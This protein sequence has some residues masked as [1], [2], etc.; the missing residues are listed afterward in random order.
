ML[1]ALDAVSPIAD[2]GAIGACAASTVIDDIDDIDGIDV[3]VDIGD[4]AGIDAS[5]A[6]AKEGQPASSIR[7]RTVL[8]CRLRRAWSSIRALSVSIRAKVSGAKRKMLSDIA[9]PS[10]IG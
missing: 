2:S 9:V 5:S 10:L 8:R 6:I 3:L 1:D 7:R 4:S